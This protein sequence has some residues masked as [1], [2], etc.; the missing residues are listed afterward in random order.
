MGRGGGGAALWLHR[1]G[2]LSLLLAFAELEHQ[3]V[4]TMGGRCGIK[5]SPEL[6]RVAKCW[7]CGEDFWAPAALVAWGSLF[8]STQR[9]L[10]L[11]CSRGGAVPMSVG[12]LSR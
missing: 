2:P 11:P 4:F 5:M 1:E 6:Q 3:L 9:Q 8:T 10:L 7:R 12:V